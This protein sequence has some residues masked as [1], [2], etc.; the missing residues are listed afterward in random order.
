MLRPSTH[1]LPLPEDE[2]GGNPVHF[3]TDSGG[4]LVGSEGTQAAHG[5]LL[6]NLNYRATL[7]GLCYLLT[8]GATAKH[9]LLTHK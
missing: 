5:F 2:R 9:T 6:L 4:V 3:A 1:L 7:R 8:F